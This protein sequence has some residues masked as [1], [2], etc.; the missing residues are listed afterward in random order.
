MADWDGMPVFQC[1]SAVPRNGLLLGPSCRL[2]ILPFWFG[3]L[4][5]NFGPGGL[6]I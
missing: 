4:L 3:L 1:V 5:L 6:L 2:F